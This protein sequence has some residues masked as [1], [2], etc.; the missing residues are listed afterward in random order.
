MKRTA[1]ILASVGAL[2]AVT[3]F[4][5]I[6]GTNGWNPTAVPASTTPATQPT[7]DTDVAA[8]DTNNTETGSVA[9]SDVS[10]LLTYLIEEEKLAHDVYDALNDMWGERVFWNISRSESKHQ[11]QVESLL[12]AYSIDDPRS[13]EPGVFVNVELQSLYD[14]LMAKGSES[15]TAAIEVGILIEET[16]IADLT[17]AIAAIDDPTIDA[18]LQRLLDASYNHLGAFTRQL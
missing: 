16:D 5:F 18:T 9:T 13:S 4:G 7:T 11:D 12:T 15:R 6:V 17:D 1:I 10:D 14:T 3:T 2:V 8:D